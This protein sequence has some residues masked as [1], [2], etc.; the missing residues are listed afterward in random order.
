[1]NKLCIWSLILAFFAA[2]AP[3]Q[4][5]KS[6]SSRNESLPSAN[7]LALSEHWSLQSSCKVD[8]KGEVLSTPTFQ[9][10]GWY[11][12]SVPTT[13]FAALVKHKVYPDPGFGMNL[14]SVPGVTYPIGTNFSNIAMQQDSPYLVPWWYRKEFVLPASYRGKSI[15]LQ[16]GGINYRANIWLNGKQ[17]AKS[18]DVAG[19][20]RTYEFNVTGIAKPDL[21]N[22]LAVQVFAPTEKDL[23]ITFVDWNPAPPDKNMGLWREVFL[24]VSGPV[25]LRYPTVISHVDAAGNAQL[26]VTALLK[27]ASKEPV[28]G[29]LKGAI[30]RYAAHLLELYAKCLDRVKKK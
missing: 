26:T 16:F 9:P 2:F 3:A 25:G 19:A 23:A 10:R 21:E 15:W 12:V 7:K 4:Q 1:M 20:W 18:D 13:V 11:D 14:R 29:T 17:I 22:V 24:T 8:Q 5:N 28:R 6:R 30:D 27:N